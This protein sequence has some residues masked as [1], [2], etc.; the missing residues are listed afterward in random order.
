MREIGERKS[1]KI[2]QTVERERKG[3][4]KSE[5]IDQTVRRERTGEM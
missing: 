3:K 5:E 2:D 4:R 1:Q